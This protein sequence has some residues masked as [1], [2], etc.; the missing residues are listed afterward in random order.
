MQ[1]TRQNFQSVIMMRH[2]SFL[3]RQRCSTQFSQT[4]SQQ[5]ERSV[6][7]G[8]F[9]WRSLWS[10]TYY[11]RH[12][13]AGGPFCGETENQKSGCAVEVFACSRKI[14][15]ANAAKAIWGRNRLAKILI[16]GLLKKTNSVTYLYKVCVPFSLGLRE[17]AICL[18]FCESYLMF[19]TSHGII[20]KMT[21]RSKNQSSTRGVR[22]LA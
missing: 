19:V 22:D 6:R 10:D 11:I 12:L 2:S 20:S 9:R 5:G 13:K 15:I 8:Y 14:V 16:T 17:T 18:I 4:N 7:A 1:G 21:S 3:C